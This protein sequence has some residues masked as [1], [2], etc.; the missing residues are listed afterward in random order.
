MVIEIFTLDEFDRENINITE[1]FRNYGGSSNIKFTKLYRIVSKNNLSYFKKIAEDVLVDEIVENYRIF[2]ETKLSDF[3]TPIII[4][5][6]FKESVTDI[7]GES[8]KLAIKD[9]GIGRVEDVRTAKRFY[10]FK[11]DKKALSFIMENYA[12]ELIHKVDLKKF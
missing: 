4:D 9:A 7:C 8:V 5:I 1:A 6:W 12:N 2:D 11:P 10:F 3:K